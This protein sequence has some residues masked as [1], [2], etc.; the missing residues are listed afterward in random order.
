MTDQH[1]ALAAGLLKW[2]GAI[3]LVATLAMAAMSASRA[4]GSQ[5][6]AVDRLSVEV[7]RLDAAK[8]DRALV[9]AMLQQNQ[10]E[11]EDIKMLLRDIREAMTSNRRSR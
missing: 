11:H 3:G 10:R 8:A 1:K 2:V 9:D 6:E 4:L 5:A 7:T